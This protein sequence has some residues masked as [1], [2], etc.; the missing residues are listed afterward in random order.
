[1]RYL[2]NTW[3]RET[4]PRREGRDAVGDRQ[5]AGLLRDQIRLCVPSSSSISRA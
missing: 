5:A 2:M 4:A 1:M 3:K